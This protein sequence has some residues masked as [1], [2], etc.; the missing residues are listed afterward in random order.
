MP[1]KTK[2]LHRVLR[3]PWTC[4][5]GCG[6]W[7]C[8]ASQVALARSFGT[9]SVA[10]STLMAYLMGLAAADLNQAGPARLYQRFV[11]WTLDDDHR[12]PV[13]GRRGHAP[14]P[15]APPRLFPCDS[16]HEVEPPDRRPADGSL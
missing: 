5:A 7:P 6:D 1:D 13:C 10:L 11:G 16:L 15:G 12:C 4:A 9:D 2:A 3:P 8:G 14:L